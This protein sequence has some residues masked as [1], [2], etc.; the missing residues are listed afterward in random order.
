MSNRFALHQ[1]DS[2]SVLQTLTD[3]S[4]DSVVTDPP[5]GIAF[6]GKAWDAHLERGRFVED[7]TPIFAQCLRV[8]KPGAHALVWALP[9]TAH[10]TTAALEDAGWEIRDVIVHL[11]GTGFPKSAKSA[12]K[13]ASEHWILCRKSLDGTIAQTIQKH[14]TGALNIDACRVEYASDSDLSL[15]LSKNPG[16]E[17][18]IRS[19]V[20]GGG[21]RSQQRVD[22]T[23]RFPPNLVLSHAEGCEP[24]GT[25]RVRTAKNNGA[26]AGTTRNGTMG[27]FAEDAWLRAHADASGM[28]TVEAWSC[29]DGCPVAELDRQSVEGGMHGAGAARNPAP[30][31]RE[32]AATS[33]HIHTSRMHRLGDTGGASRFFPRFG[34]FPKASSRDRHSEGAAENRHPTVKNTAL[35]RWLCRLITPPGGLVL[36]PFAGS[37]STG[38]AAL[39]EGLRFLGIEKEAEYA[40][41]ARRRLQWA[42][43]GATDQADLFA[44]ASSACR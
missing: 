15:S 1:G 24:A 3:N 10:W 44:S 6:M 39:R 9:R 5:A 30:I 42:A 18:G 33:F 8:A 21:K 22:D 28:E 4:V 38:V 23:G 37:G 11:F 31:R 7:M 26:P 17:D 16:R 2:A 41:I 12:L 20:Y 13:P 36:D 43:A 14:G 34:Y 29:A 19:A 25:K 27:D 32:Y 40:E 35:M